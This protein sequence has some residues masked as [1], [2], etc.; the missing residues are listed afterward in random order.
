MIVAIASP[1]AII[2][3]WEITRLECKQSR[4]GRNL[5]GDKRAP[6]VDD[7]NRTGLQE[8]GDKLAKKRC[9]KRALIGYMRA[10]VGI[11]VNEAY[12]HPE[13]ES[14]SKQGC[15]KGKAFFSNAPQ[16]D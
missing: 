9:P 12:T 3:E 13:E 8:K 15:I 2:S 1:G 7:E 14:E 4:E 10:Q 16:P 11:S 6:R 5:H